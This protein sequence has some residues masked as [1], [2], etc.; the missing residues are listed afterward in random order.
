M[1][2]FI[3]G[4]VW[5]LA[6]IIAIP[7]FAQK[8]QQDHRLVKGTL[9]NGFTYYIYPNDQKNKQSYI[10]LFLNAGS[11]QEK[12]SQQG[13]A[14]FVEHMAFNGSKNYPKNDI[15]SFLESLGVKFGADLNAHTGYDET[16]YKITINTEDKDKLEKAIDIVADWAFELSFDQQEIDKERGV[17]IEEWRTRQ[18]SSSR[19]SEHYLPLIFQNSRYAERKPIG[20]LDI[21][22]NFDRP[23]ILDFYNSWYRPNLMAIAVVTNQDLKS[24]EK[25][26]KQ[27]FKK[28]KNPKPFPVRENYSIPARQDTLYSI[29]TDKEATSIDFS[30]ISTI[31][32]MNK[33]KTEI[34]FFT[35]LQ[36]SFTNALSKKRFERITQL[37]ASFKSGSMTVGNLLINNGVTSGGATLYENNIEQGIKDYIYEKQRILNFGF[38][39]TEIEEIKKEQLAALERS[40]KNDSKTNAS[41]IIANMKNDFTTGSTLLS[42]EE[43]YRLM[44]KYMPAIDSVL[45]LQYSRQFYKPGNTVVMLTAPESIKDKLPTQKQLAAWDFQAQQNS[46]IEVWSDDEKVPEKLLPHT[47][48]AG[49]IVKIDSIKEVGV[50]KWTLS[51]GLTVYVKKNSD[52]KNHIA[53]TGYRKG[54]IMSLDSTKYVNAV[55]AKNVIGASGAGDFTRRALTKYLIGNTSSATFIFS[56]NR[57]GVAASA[58]IKDIETMFQLLYLKWTAPRADEYVFN[59]IKKKALENAKNAN[60]SPTTLYNKRIAEKLR[61][62]DEFSTD[63]DFERIEKEL[64]YNEILS[65][66]Q[67]KFKSARDFTFILIG[68]FDAEQIKPYIAQ[69]LA[70]LPVGNYA[71]ENK[72]NTV[73]TNANEADIL[74]YQGES[75]KATVNIFYQNNNI[76]YDYPE[77]LQYEVLQEVLKVKLRKNLRE[78]N[79]GV[80]GVGVNVG[81]TSIPSPLLRTRIVFTCAPERKDFLIE[82]VGYELDKI[83]K[84][85]KYFE[86]ELKNIK[87]QLLVDYQKQY[88]KGT[89][90]SAQLRNHFYFGFKDWSYFTNYNNMLDNITAEQLSKLTREKLLKS[91]KI[92]AVLM[93][94]NNENKN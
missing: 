15:I 8:L 79:S 48:N 47:V 44:K 73:K 64:K 85:P 52:R 38:T 33:V 23:T 78:E 61:S 80:Y 43:N 75:E 70:S 57:E 34:D 7:G 14:H 83:A 10:Q 6:M 87:T 35:N 50:Q 21:L 37:D 49:E 26:I 51:N 71:G 13:L 65:T 24:V 41:A 20:K 11:L 45:L 30:Y 72:K 81:A 55:F 58:D 19:M 92:Q 4:W 1:N 16:V 22:R 39:R 40:V 32:P 77:I 12:D 9:K 17:I 66:Y 42:K 56:G 93:P 2:K 94:S 3:G 5:F 69:Y 67:S 54:G 25:Y 18:S 28:A 90:W 74:M 86:E 27:E 68:D 89:F 53:L 88:S 82:Q 29:V 84:D 46:N 91:H 31:E 62:E 63:I 76:T 60:N 59:N 36:K